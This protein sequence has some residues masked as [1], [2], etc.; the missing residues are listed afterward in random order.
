MDIPAPTVNRYCVRAFALHQDIIN[1]RVKLQAA[2][3]KM[4]FKPFFGS[5][6][7]HGEFRPGLGEGAW[8]HVIHHFYR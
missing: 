8:G 2:P 6:P 5:L 1:V 7:F 3:R 4:G